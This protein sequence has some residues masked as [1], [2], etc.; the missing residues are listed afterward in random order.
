MGQSLRRVAVVTG[1][2]S[3][4]GQ[5]VSRRLSE[6]GQPVGVLDMDGA[7]AEELAEALRASG[8]EAVAAQVDVADDDAVAAATE[9]V[10]AALGP[11]TVLVTSAA[12]SGFIPFEQ[13]TRETWD[14]TLAVN[15]TGTYNC[16]KATIGDM[17]AARWGRIV[18]ISS[19]AGQT[20]SS[21]QAH[22][23]ASK[24]GVIALTKSVAL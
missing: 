21:R 20:G 11:V 22:Y 9:R 3:G 10:R 12:T 4:L 16:I 14:R 15:L 6:L 2:A 17:V 5:A 7:A 8:G 1:G 24:G 23:S 18:T 19:S 13:L